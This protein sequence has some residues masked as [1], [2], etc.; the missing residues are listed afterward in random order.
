M[1]KKL[2]ANKA[3]LD[4]PKPE[5]SKG[6]KGKERPKYFWETYMEK[7]RKAKANVRPSVLQ[8]PPMS[9]EEKIKLIVCGIIMLAVPIAVILVMS[10]N[11]SAPSSM[12]KPAESAPAPKAATKGSSDEG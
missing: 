4:E 12:D 9:K 11:A 8:K 6:D 2:K 10:H 7:R 1:L 5:K 3:Q